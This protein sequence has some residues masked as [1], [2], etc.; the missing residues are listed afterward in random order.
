MP[1]FQFQIVAQ[2]KD[3]VQQFM[4]AAQTEEVV[5]EE[6][7]DNINTPQEIEEY[8][9]F[10]WA[11]QPPDQLKRLAE[12]RG[13]VLVYVEDKGVV[14]ERDEELVQRVM[15]AHQIVA[16]MNLT[17]ETEMLHQMFETYRKLQEDPN[18]TKEGGENHPH[19]QEKNP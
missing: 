19:V 4:E 1:T 17:T 6:W 10:G 14:D 3:A 12:E 13:V 9:G 5:I 11:H 7:G 16:G 8:C 15:Q 2:T 18:Y